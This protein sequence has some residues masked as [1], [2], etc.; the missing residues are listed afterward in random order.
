MPLLM[1]V[2]VALAAIDTVLAIVLGG[3]YVRNH[4]EIRSPFTLGLLLFA[5]FLVVHNG[6]QVYHFLTMMPYF[7]ATGEGLLFAENVLQTAGLVAL[8]AATLR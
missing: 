4:R 5:L 3:V 8:V 1:D 6:L 7:I 2:S